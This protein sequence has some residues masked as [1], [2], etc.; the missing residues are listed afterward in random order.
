MN[1]RRTVITNARLVDGTGSPERHADVTFEDGIITEVGTSGSAHRN[2]SR[3]IDADGM[4]VTPGWVDVHTHYDAQ[5]TWDPFLTPSGWHGVTTAVMGNC[6]VGFAPAAP[7]RHEWLIELMEGVEDIPG[8]AMVEGIEWEWTSFP[9][10]LDAL[11]RKPRVMDLGTQ[12]G[13][14]ALRAFVMGDRGANNEDANADDIA[15]MARITHEALRAGALGFSTSRTALHKSK[16][17][18]YVPGTSAQPDELLGIADAVARAGHGIFQM[19]A[20][21]WRRPDSEWQW[22]RDVAG[23]TGVRF[24]INLNQPAD[25]PE[26]WRETLSLMEA[27][28]RDGMNIEAQVAGRSIGLIMCLQG[29]VNPLMMHSAYN[30]VAARPVGARLAALREAARDARLLVERPAHRF[31]EQFVG[32]NVHI[33]FP[34]IGGNINYEPTFDESIA[35]IAQR[36]GASP[37]AIMIDQLLSNDGQGMIYRPFLNYA[38]GDLSMTHELLQHPLTR[39]GL[40]DAGAHCGVICDGGMPTFLLTH[41][42]RDRARGPRLSLEQV[43]ARQTRKTAE[44]HGLLDRGV[45]APGMRADVNIID[46]D[47]L[48]FE[49]PRVV[50]DLPAQGR[51]L[52]QRAS[53]YVATFCAGVQTVDHDEFTGD[54]P[55]KLLRGPQHA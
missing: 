47:R 13:H 29:T 40:S 35:G 26:L 24:S 44:L 1:S 18:E 41:W 27:A 33:M 16:N 54:L 49:V 19:A 12:I 5:A 39:N 7:E 3:L 8:S 4:L 15:Q 37:H 43:V 25:E 21:H 23:K 20:E 9:E 11:E 52:A 48:S 45:I 14:G 22:M 55:G 50:H 17:G 36:S 42:V 30:E 34:I 53:G 38:Y 2:G 10:Y 31:Y 46:F 51:R 6:G 32:D 28:Q